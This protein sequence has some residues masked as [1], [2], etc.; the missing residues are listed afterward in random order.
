MNLERFLSILSKYRRG[1][2]D[3]EESRFI[4]EWYDKL[5]HD[6]PR[7]SALNGKDR[8]K[9]KERHWSGIR[10]RIRDSKRPHGAHV[11]L[12]WYLGA[13]ASLIV[14]VFLVSFLFEDPRP[15]TDIA[16][17]EEAYVIANPGPDERR[18]VLTDSSKVTLAGG[19]EMRIA[20]DFNKSRREVFL[21]GEGF[22]EVAHDSDRPFLVYVDGL[23]TKVEGTSFRITAPKDG[24]A[25]TVAV[26]TGRVSVSTIQAGKTGGSEYVVLAP[27]QQ[28]IFQRKTSKLLTTLVETP[29]VIP[30]DEKQYR[31][32]FRDTPVSEIFEAIEE[33]YGIDIIYDSALATCAI[34][35]VF[36]SDGLYDRLDLICKA[37]NASF[38]VEG[39]QIRIRGGSCGTEEGVDQ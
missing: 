30:R 24:D 29:R 4:E 1:S 38:E 18:F 9:L 3:L 35:T 22:F 20:E 26:S 6:M 28:V 32:K 10:E 31:I 15:E 19:S 2:A 39:V 5:G 25:V 23:T 11:S 12:V 17:I 8:E 34:N 13:A 37:I 16:R 27:N 36:N 7:Q 33:M 21:T 14:G